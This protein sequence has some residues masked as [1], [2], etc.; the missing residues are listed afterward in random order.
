MALVDK[1]WSRISIHR[2]I[3]EFLRAERN[4]NFSFHP[5]WLSLIDSPNLS[6]PLEKTRFGMKSAA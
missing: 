1:V 4:K 3:S 2:V 5:P 6:D